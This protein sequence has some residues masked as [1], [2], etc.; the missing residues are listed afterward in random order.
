MAAFPNHASALFSRPTPRPRSRRSDSVFAETPPENLECPICANILDSPMLM[1]CCGKRLC[2][3]CV[4]K[5]RTS[6]LATANRCPYCSKEFTTMVDKGIQRLVNEVKVYCPNRNLGCT[7]IGDFSKKAAHIDVSNSI[8]GDNCQYQTVPCRIAG[9][10]VTLCRHSLDEHEVNECEF[11]PY[12]CHYCEKYN[13]TFGDVTNNHFK[14]CDKLPVE[15]PKGCDL[16]SLLRGSLNEHLEKTCPLN[17]IV[18]DYLKVG[19][20]MVRKRQDMKRHLEVYAQYHNSLLLKEF[21]QMKASFS[22]QIV[23][24]QAECFQR[25]KENKQLSTRIAVAQARSSDIT[26]EMEQKLVD[27]K[28]KVDQLNNENALLKSELT[29][30]KNNG[31]SVVDSST[32]VQQ[33]ATKMEVVERELSNLNEAQPQKILEEAKK[34]TE[35]VVGEVKQE[36]T[37]L[38]PQIETLSSSVEQIKEEVAELKTHEGVYSMY[39]SSLQKGVDLVKEKIRY[40]ESWISPRP[41]FSFTFGQVSYHVKNKVPF[42]S[43]PFYTKI[44][45]YK[46]YIRIDLHSEDST[47]VGVYCCIMRGEHDEEL[48]WPFRGVIHV[49]LQNHRGDHSHF[50]QAIRYDDTT[51]LSKAGRV[52]NG[53]KN[54]VHGHSKFIAHKEL[55]RCNERQYLQG[56]ALDFQIT[57]VEEFA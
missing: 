53:D 56:D 50:N 39:A 12:S 31:L 45:G 42:L 13:S 24:L 33:L 19:C 20:T 30:L 4:T 48:H 11:R 7:W 5:I 47:H 38:S 10:N 41:P 43:P 32:V 34:Q 35:E 29:L 1:S 23:D 55:H 36:V 52:Q 16:D 25:K 54:Y 17:E 26:E 2:G 49:Q 9:C 46:M 3:A 21:V 27:I 37:D 44:R 40:I 8:L 14:L 15:C 18:C 6:M 51:N 28:A 22:E 57:K